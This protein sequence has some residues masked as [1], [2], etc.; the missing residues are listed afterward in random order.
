M[1]LPASN[2]LRNPSLT[3]P[4]PQ[5]LSDWLNPRLPSD[6]FASWGVK[7]GTKNVINLWIEISEGES[8]LS[9]S[10]P[11]IRTLEVVSVRVIRKDNKVLVESHQELSD[12]SV[13]NRGR[14]L[15]EKMK[16]CESVESAVLRAIKEELG[17]I[18]G[19]D[20]D[21][22]EIVRIRP[23]SY[24]KKVEER[25]SVSYPGL[26]ARYVLHTI[27]ATVEGLPEGDFWTE[28]VEEYEGLGDRGVA[29]GAITCKKHVW[30]W[31]D[32][33]SV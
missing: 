19:R 15:S 28:E 32:S 30:K 24:A 29:E 25:V 9:D 26:L 33:Y 5:S 31:V 14:P 22:K 1:F 8:S 6:S 10:V 12:G 4:T 11:P 21:F 16:P 23:N 17:Q 18:V 27:D 2:G 20:S 13:R 3:F 7:P